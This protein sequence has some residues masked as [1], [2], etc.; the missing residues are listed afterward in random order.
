MKY[1]T[2][3]K[4]LCVLAI[5][6]CMTL[7]SMP[8][9][10]Y[11]EPT[12]TE[13]DEIEEIENV[14]IIENATYLSTPEDILAL[15]E[16]CVDDT[17]S[18]DKVFVLKNDIDMSEVEFTGIPTFGG[19]FIGQG[20]CISGLHMEQDMTVMG[21][22]RYLQKTAVVDHLTLEAIVESDGNNN[23]IGAFAGINKGKIQN[24]KLIGLVSG[25]EE[26]GGIVGWNKTSGTIVNCEVEG[27]VH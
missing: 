15:A 8:L 23:Q 17:W 5:A 14:E 2:W 13:S 11:A 10:I 18:V 24:C 6:G 12:D 4:K 21:F 19:I 20:H 25:T 3:M 22:F 1:R 26:I 16:N 27:V 9:T 7:S